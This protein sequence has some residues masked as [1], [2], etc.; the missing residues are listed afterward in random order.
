[1]KP[2][3]T[4]EV[5][6]PRLIVKY[7]AKL[8]GE[9]NDINTVIAPLREQREKAEIESQAKETVKRAAAQAKAEAKSKTEIAAQAKA[10]KIANAKALIA[11]VEAVEQAEKDKSEALAAAKKLLGIKETEI[12]KQCPH[13]GAQERKDI[14]MGEWQFDCKCYEKEDTATATNQGEPK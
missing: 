7:L 6:T 4:Y 13:C 5:N 8:V 10:Q 12:K 2:P 9:V 11:Q 1:M 14:K 3:T